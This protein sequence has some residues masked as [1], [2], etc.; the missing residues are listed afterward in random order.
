MA[1]R[2]SHKLKKLRKNRRISSLRAQ[3]RAERGLRLET[4]EER[5]LLA[6]GPQLVG[7]QPNVG[8]LL[9]PNE[10]RDTAPLE[11]RFLFNSTASI[12][13]GSLPT[14][15]ANP[16]AFDS[17]QITRSGLDGQFERASVFSDFN[18][19]GAVKIEFEA[20][21]VGQAGSLI[22]IAVEKAELSD[23]SRDPTILVQGNLIQ[24]TL[25]ST[26][27]S[28]TRAADLIA[29]INTD[30][31]ASLLVTA[32]IR[33][34][35]AVVDVT[36]PEITYSPLVMTAANTA[37][38]TSSFNSVGL[39]IELAAAQVG[40]AG[41]GIMVSV[42]RSDLGIDA[43]PELATSNKTISITLN[44]NVTTPTTAQQ[45]VDAIN[46]D[47]DASALV[48]ATIRSGAGD[49]AIGERPVNY[50][51]IVLTG[52][53]DVRIEPGYLDLQV[54]SPREVVMRFKDH[55][56][57]DLYMVEVL[58]GGPTPL[59]NVNGDA[60]ED[61]GNF[62]MTFSLD[63]GAQIV[64]VVPQ[65]VTRDASG[66]LDQRRDIIEVYFNDDD[67]DP[68]TAEDPSFYQ[69]IHTGETVN[70]DDD[71]VVNPTSV[72][73]NADTDMAVLTFSAPIEDLVAAGTYRLRI[74]T[75]ETQP[76][77][78]IGVPVLQDPGS[79][80]VTAMDLTGANLDDAALMLSTDI[81]SSLFPLDYPGGNDEPGHRDI[82][83]IE[84]H[85]NGGAD[86]TPGI[87]TY[88]YNFQDEYGFDP[89]GN[90]L[91]NAIT[92]IEQQRAREVFDFYAN[93]LGVNFI[94]SENRGFTIVTG[95]LRAV[96]PNVPTG[97]GGVAGIAGGGMA[98]MDLVDFQNPGDDRFGGPWF[99]VAMH[100]IGHLLGLGH[101][102]D[103]PPLT[104]Q[105]SEGSLSFGQA[106]EPVFPGDQDIVHGQNLYRPESNDIDLYK[107]ELND[108]G[109]FNVETYAERLGNPSLLDTV[110]TLYQAK[111]DS[112]GN[113]VSRELISRND[114]YYAADSYIEMMLEKGTYY[115]GVTASGN[116]DYDPSVEDTGAGGRSQGNY[117]LRL[118]FRPAADN[119]IVDAT[120]VPLDGDADGAPGGVYNFWFRAAAPSDGTG[121]T[122][123]RTIF[124]DK[125]SATAAG[126]ETGDG[127]LANPF[128]YIPSALAASDPQDIIRLVGNPGDDGDITTLGDN[129]A[130]QIGFSK[131]GGAVLQDGETLEVPQGVALM[132]D[133]NAIL[134]LRRARIGVGSSSQSLD[135]SGGALQVLGTPRIID[136]SGNVMIDETGQPIAGSAYFTS[137]QDTE[138]GLDFNPDQVSSD[139][140]PGDWGGIVFRSDL[141]IAD[142]NR[143]VYGQDGIFINYVNHAEMTY[144][145]GEVMINGRSL[146]V[147]PLQMIDERPTLTF[148]SI[149][150]SSFVAMSANPNSFEEDNFHAPKFQA[151]P[152][153]SDYARVG[154]EI[155]HN[156]LVENSMNGLFIRMTTPAG[157]GTEELTK[158]ARWDDTDITH[159]ISENLVIQGQPGGPILE[160][161]APPVAVVTLEAVGGLGSLAP[162]QYEYKLVY[163]DADGN[164]GPPSDPTS[165][166]DVTATGGVVLRNLPR[167]TLSDPY[168]SRRIYRAEVGT[169]RYELVA[170]INGEDTVFTDTGLLVG[171][172][173][174]QSFNSVRT[175]LAGRLSVDP[176]TIVKLDRVRI[177]GAF[178]A[179]FIS[180]GLDGRP[181]V[182][183]SLNDVRY[184][185]GGTF[186]TSLQEGQGDA[187]PGDW[188]G[189]FFGH[190][191]R[192]SIDFSIIAYAGGTTR[193]EGS[194]AGFNPIEIHQ[195][196]V[197]I[198]D[199]RFEHNANGQGGQ[200]PANRFGLG[201]NDN[202]LIFVRGA[203]PVI[204]SNT[205]I[206]NAGSVISINANS[207][208]HLAKNDPGRSIGP[209]NIVAGVNDNQGPL[210]RLNRLADNE[211]NGMTVRGATLTTQSVWDDTDIVHVVRDTII[212]PDFHTYGG[213]RLESNPRESLV[214]KLQGT[215]AGFTATG[216]ELDITDRIGGS[217]QIVG[218][219]R[220]P[221]VLTALSDDSV[222]A[223]FTPGGLPQND[224]NGDGKSSGLLPTGPEV[225]NGTL[226]DNDVAPGIPGQ[227]AFDVFDGGSSDFF[228]R[229]GISAQGNNTSFVDEN[230]IFD[231]TNYFDVGADG[232]AQDLRF[233]TVTMPAALIDHDLVVSEGTFT[234]ENGL[235]AWHVESYLNDGESIVYNEITL[236]SDQPLGTLQYINYLDEDV[237]FVSDD[238]LYLTGTPGTNDFRAFTLDGPERVGFSQGGIVEPGAGLL[239]ATFDGWAADQYF[240]LQND[241]QG[242][243]TTYTIAGNVNTAN[244]RPFNDPELG[245]VYGL[246][247]VTTALAWSVDPNATQATITSFLELVPRNPA[248]AG[249]PGDWRSV[250]L[251]ALS[252]DRNVDVATEREPRDSTTGPD[253][254]Q[255]PDNAQFIGQL[256][257]DEKSADDTLRLGFEV[258]GVVS[259][260]DDV[261]VYSFQ[262]SAGTEVWLDI[263]RTSQ[264]LDTVV[265]LVDANGRIIA[266]SDN[267]YYEEIGEEQLFSDP[268]KIA[269]ENVNPLR[270]SAT[271]FYPESAL[272]EPKDLWSTNPRDAGMRLVLPGSQGTTNTYYVRIRSS[273]VEPGQ[274]K[275]DLL[276]P[277]K[278]N[279]G[280][281]SGIYQ[282][283][284]R[285][286]EVDEM[287]GST[288]QYADIRF[289][290]NGIE[291][292]GQP[293]HS[294]LTGEAAEDAT[295][296][297]SLGSAQPLG[298]VLNSDRGTL[299]VAG[300]LSALGDV[301]FY[302]F[303]VAFD[304]VQNIGGFT[305]SVQHLATV[306]DID[307]AD[308]L[309][310]ANTRITVFDSNGN[311]VLHA[312][313]SNIADDQ[314]APLNGTDMDDLSRGSAGT[315]DP[316]VGTQELPVG[317]YYVAISSDA[318]IP[319]EFQQFYSPTPANTLFRLEPVSSV[320]RIAEDHINSSYVSTS[321]PPQ[322]PV[323]FDDTTAVPYNLGDVV[324]FVST[325]LGGPD[326]GRLFTVDPFTGTVETTV[327]NDAAN[328]DLTRN[329]EDIAMRPDGN[330]FALSVD[331]TFRVNDAGSGNYL[332]IDTGNG[333]INQVG[334]DGIETWQANTSTPPGDVRHDVGYQFLA[335]TYGDPR[336]YT[337]GGPT[338]LFA[339]GDRTVPGLG[340]EYTENV[341]YRL[342][343]DTGD[344]VSLFQDRTG[345]N[346]PGG[347]RYLGAGTQIVERGFLDT[348]ADPLGI[349]D[350]QLLL[351]DATD[352][353]PATNAT[354]F[355]ITDG[356]L[357]SVDH[358][359][360]PLTPAVFFEFNAGP[361]IRV[362]PDPATGAFVRDGD[363]FDIDGDSFEFD[364]GSVIVMNAASGS[365]IADGVTV[366]MT[367]D[368]LAPV[369]LTFEYTRT[370]N[371]APGNIPIFINNGMS[372]AV[373][374]SQ[375][376]GAINGAAGFGITAETLPGND[377]ITLRGES[378]TTGATATSPLVAIEGTPGGVGDYVIPIEETSDLNEYG[379]AIVTTFQSVPTVTAGW[380]GERINF[381][382][383]GVGSFTALVNR[384]LFTDMGS[385]GS[386]V[387]GLSIP[388]LAQDTAQDLAVRVAAAI[389]VNMTL[390]QDA[391]AIDRTV[392]LGGGAI[393]ETAQNPL[394]IAG[395]A[396]GGLITGIAFVG[397][398]MYAVTDTGGLFTVT[399]PGGRGA[400]AVYI[401]TSAQDLQGIDFQALSVGPARTEDGRYSQILFGMD[402]NGALYAFDT[403]GQ[404]Q[405][406]FVDGQTSVET[407][408]GAVN[409]IAFSTLE[410]N[411][412]DFVS[413][414]RAREFDAGHGLELTFDQTRYAP[415]F[416][417]D[418]NTSLHFGRTRDRNLVPITYD[419]PGGAYGSMES[420]TFSLE[421]YSA[422][423]K[424]VL[425]FNYFAETEEESSAP[426]TRTPMLDSL[427]VFV[428][429]GSGQWD[430]VTTNNS[431]FPDEI[432]YS[433]NNVQETFD[434]NTGWRQVRVE[435]DNYAG[436]D[437]VQIRIDFS[438]AGATNLGDPNTFGS[439]LRMISGA[440]L[441]DGETLMID[442]V[443]FEIDMGYTLVAASGGAVQDGD[444]FRIDDGA[445]NDV[446]FEFDSTGGVSNPA[447]VP[448][449]IDGSMTADNVALA[450]EQAILGRFLPGFRVEVNGNRINI[451]D[452]INADVTSTGLDLQGSPGTA[453]VPIVVDSGMVTTQVVAVVQQALADEFAG[454]VTE[455]VKTN[456]NVVRV[457]GHT[458]VDRGPFG[459]SDSLPGDTSGN[460]FS[461]LRGQDNAYEGIYLDDFIVGFAEHGEI[462]TNAAGNNTFYENPEYTAPN[463]APPEILVGPY[464]L[465]IRQS[466]KYGDSVQAP[467][468]LELFRSFDSNARL[469][470]SF[471]LVAPAA[472]E[473]SD[474]QT[475]TLSDGV[476]TLTFEFDDVTI[477]DGVTPGNV[478]INFNPQ[479]FDFATGDRRPQTASE[480]A[481]R[482]RDAINSP[483]SQAVLGITAGLADG[484]VDNSTSTSSSL[485]N[486]YGNVDT[487]VIDAG[488]R[489]AQTTTDGNALRDAILGDAFAPVGDAIYSGGVT[490]AG[491]FVGGSSS[492]GIP[493]GIVLTTGDAHFV[494]G[495]NAEDGST[496]LASETGDADLDAYFAP[497]VTEDSSTL[498]FSFQVD[499]STDLFFEFVFSS[500]EYNEF[501]NSAFND[502]FAFFVDGENIGFVPGTFDPVT[503]D[504][505]N[506]G[507]PFGTGGVNENAYNNND[508]NDGGLFLETFGHDG[509]TDVFLA[510]MDGLTAGVHTIKLAISDVGDMAFDSAVFVRAFNVTEPDSSTALEGVTYTDKGDRNLFRDQ[511]QVVIHS[512][513]ISNSA[514]YGVRIDAASRSSEGKPHAG[515]VRV[516]RNV[517]DANLVPGVV[518]TNNVVA[519]NRTGGVFVAGDPNAGNV[520][521]APVPFGRVVN[522]TVYG[523]GVGIQVRDNASPTLLNNIVAD[524]S[525]GIDVDGSSSSTVIGGILYAGNG[526]TS[527]N[528]NDGSFPLYMTSSSELFVN[529]DLGN[530]YL[531]PG[532]LAIDSSI[533]SLNDRPAMKTIRQPLG[534]SDSPILAPDFDLY[535]QLRVDDPSV[536]SPS[537]LGENPFK[538]R[539]AIDRSDFSG[540]SVQLINPRDNDAVGDDRDDRETYVEIRNQTLFDFSIQI[541]DGI[542]PS[543]QSNGSGPDS[544]TVTA[545]AILVTKDSVPLE[546]GVDYRFGYD[547]TSGIIRLTPLAGIWES[548]HTYEI[549]LLNVDNLILS[550][551][552]GSMVTDGATFVLVDTLGSSATFE[553][554]SGFSLQVPDTGGAAFIDG[555]TFSITQTDPVT[556]DAVTTTFEFDDNGV[557]SPA[558]V[559]V[560]FDATDTPDDVGGTLAAAIAGAGIG[561]NATRW[562]DGFVQVGGDV[563][564]TI[565]TSTSA[566]TQS[567]QP[568][569]VD[570]NLAVPFVAHIDFTAEQMADAIAAAINASTL[571]ISAVTQLNDVVLVGAA[572]ATGISTSNVSA[573]RDL[574]GNILKANR[575]DGST[576]FTLS[577]GAGRDYGDAPS[578][579]PVLKADNGA[580][581]EIV[582]GY[583]LGATI[584][585]S[586]DGQPSPNA[587]ADPGD[588]GVAFAPLTAAYKTTVNVT[589]VGIGADR[590]GL[591]DAWV[592]FNSDGDWDDAGEQIFASEALVN[593]VNQLEF[594][595]DGNAI[596]GDTFARFR[597]SSVGGLSPTGQTSDGEVEDYKVTIGGNPWHNYA[598][599]IDTNGDT[600]VSPID[601][602]LVITLLN[603]GEDWGIDLSKPLPI[604]PLPDFAPPP[605]Y[606]VNGDSFVS[607][608]DALLVISALNGE[609]EGE[610]QGEGEG[611]NSSLASVGSNR[612]LD[613]GRLDNQLD[614][615]LDNGLLGPSSLV[616]FS[617]SNTA[618]NE[619][620]LA[621]QLVSSNVAV[622]EPLLTGSLLT[623]SL[624]TGTA[625]N[626]GVDPHGA[627]VATHFQSEDLEDLLDDIAGDVDEV[628]AAHDAHDAFFASFDA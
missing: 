247:D 187:Q 446:T 24:V 174:Q 412:W 345:P 341:L 55:L 273:N 372:T 350:T 216:R 402:S 416:R 160:Q 530:F 581:H 498:E 543:D 210:V 569:V 208:N 451:P 40:I 231:F 215:D 155:H 143:T 608:I 519:N 327:R 381:S 347:P 494:E 200:A 393:F 477:G 89:Q 524:T 387:A 95:D 77:V 407:G 576:I 184:G 471:V 131:V 565:D 624:L 264:S 583:R 100:E 408:L 76:L 367:D 185:S 64:A 285:L 242:P 123:P 362:H 296:N 251:D 238:L 50:S 73:Y 235:I 490:S 526:V 586:A 365:Q 621:T 463:T 157:S 528:G 366:T 610:S 461:N 294:P 181:I 34:G 163:V 335:M 516:T 397:G 154:P 415:D 542:A 380:D 6:V 623:G 248:T 406:M 94:E 423:D 23:E 612:L 337:T 280:L 137:L 394:R 239:N 59:V 82:D 67:L 595:V 214:V 513:T 396:P 448:V 596:V 287:P 386:T 290:T 241:I 117:Q 600:W 298:N 58:G 479:Q 30:A 484:T 346:N 233:T 450:M 515:P 283:Q 132:I 96:D 358:D 551:R 211:L 188:G 274:P 326:N 221:V 258:Q 138:V 359:A 183:T 28:E 246:A 317:T 548:D 480:M 120:G 517:N 60:F 33:S 310:R 460:F 253:N 537:G 578:Q 504:T 10:T 44:S 164:E 201:T 314:P 199:S 590:P 278:L 413:G 438:T 75:D 41:N 535:G 459:L 140:L 224:T 189:I 121:S 462:A 62:Q 506:G 619:V 486:L 456:E 303:E 591:L 382:G 288:V 57:D 15:E 617:S 93:Y 570:G 378:E 369:T 70:T 458:V 527:A 161:T 319:S 129:V 98:V 167:L 309:A 9:T 546:E 110:L 584:L 260:P 329:I 115:V 491:F 577:L 116:L 405:P 539:G 558:N 592:D 321:T 175:R 437:N 107:F 340:N 252:N 47:A 220:F 325:E 90:V 388:F 304:S 354:T 605:Y 205:M 119:T 376:V 503:I 392:A 361:E 364:T 582:D 418:G 12:D 436:Y 306:L 585:S 383:A 263:D 559:R 282:L 493:A 45:L 51:P 225:D 165:V 255:N 502:V 61:G 84:T 414:D 554:D 433:P 271:D 232:N 191:S 475:F 373:L 109:L 430:L 170:Q 133:A 102:Y 307:Y 139:A 301:D 236:T 197:R 56:P 227:F 597:F 180:E 222:G 390:P 556:L 348:T 254:N 66:N 286:R 128:G 74:G 572:S 611:G 81:R 106:A 357:L 540:P 3:R 468:R 442:G 7:I 190:L 343:A 550:A 240:D 130:Y 626:S 144:G 385:D 297:N 622:A 476:G 473:I 302:Q 113:E 293:T 323:L 118:N 342:N 88:Y 391:T 99:N 452:A 485:V 470:E 587:D 19:L 53:N 148:N 443:T 625:A 447:N 429:D 173:L 11:L 177:E 370:G 613:G 265:E 352:V 404:L 105:G 444:T 536:A 176:G 217:V 72:Q 322:I 466:E 162:G 83:W 425:Y 244:L 487:N 514:E 43:L 432:S 229:G 602:L 295:T 114:D 427:R 52:A 324:F 168:E 455:A 500:E 409:G 616:T 474:G 434:N 25:N 101:T 291:I 399:N 579:Y 80:F 360:D 172:E 147:A 91:H 305:N 266:L 312:S 594:D 353:N 142:A 483:E 604:P 38:A 308:G 398:T 270:K 193:L 440:E 26:E 112:D 42:S 482:I 134:K 281:T 351:V 122:D 379:N 204:V 21:E 523:G 277:V 492:I 48:T 257:A 531:A 566:L 580:A 71:Q 426:A 465:E 330:L 449:V 467:D 35:S 8:E 1:I 533:E 620:S 389:D 601:A 549:E 166:V 250:R 417:V 541:I 522:N 481:G 237:R 209:I 547:A 489:V 424:P 49:T 384:G 567:G 421:G 439:E 275:D 36:T 520:A 97:P 435:L 272:G 219:P 609:G 508:R 228:S 320:E 18:T 501:V 562:A 589:A 400:Q 65:P 31:A 145:G 488:L 510:R 108:P 27:G 395:A 607:P 182:Y 159:I 555:E 292:L 545:A 478:E 22:Q 68:V 207:L 158:S 276:D 428:T 78:P 206:D 532:A 69:L 512:N 560:P 243:G 178:G 454:G 588:D 46:A 431:Y 403:T 149:S 226:I 564:T 511:G 4:L 499:T 135:R 334:D 198:A 332:Q 151:V 338:Y 557:A 267:S 213:L 544:T 464:Q 574:A 79:S 85:L 37:S 29:A 411:P 269:P 300:N 20:V 606:D 525:V 316:F 419:W 507:N 203:Q 125:A 627:A 212:A 249:Q 614:N 356:L 202:A 469:S 86:V 339:V 234:G 103:L 509:F 534:I 39:D 169:N 603:N 54:D 573:I 124:V 223:G 156:T 368:Q 16:S 245:L 336:A 289:A 13:P 127:S 256:A 568:G 194:F 92:D 457:I 598:N 344:A 63:L 518:V 111:F 453:G 311:V 599:A 150:N 505:V 146:T 104:V 363:T 422:A 14:D 441:S 377:R 371:V 136:A 355:Q 333:A 32:R 179:Q 141:D 552:A 192:G 261:D 279:D 153:T 571:D 152:F 538:D 472:N 615:Q 171:G 315:L 5:Q 126:V 349:A 196:E 445:G 299:G 230:V 17:I 575:N 374:M 318:R 561:L 495:P 618:S 218:Q 563:N 529:K 195:A 497:F 496:G 259:T 401:P 628:V 268:L 262:A 313:D 284:V 186:D 521:D 410:E 2:R 553:Y 87:T 328:R 375:T 593:G 331:D 420:K